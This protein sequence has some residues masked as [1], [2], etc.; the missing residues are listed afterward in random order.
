MGEIISLEFSGKAAS[1][2]AVS[3][4][5]L[6]MN[7]NRQPQTERKRSAISRKSFEFLVACCEG[8][9]RQ[10]RSGQPSARR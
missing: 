6:G 9:S 3:G 1:K 4:Q 2:E 5:P 7:S 8:N 10:Q